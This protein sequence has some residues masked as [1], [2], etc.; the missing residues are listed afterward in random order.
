MKNSYFKKNILI[1][2]S[3]CVGLFSILIGGIFFVIHQQKAAET[4]I[5]AIN[6]KILALQNQA[7][8]LENESAELKKYV[9]WWLTFSENKKSIKTVKI[10]E[11]N[12][13]LINVAEKYSI[14]NPILKTALP[15]NLTNNLFNRKTVLVFFSSCSISFK[16][17]NDTKTLAFLKE[18]FDSLPGYHVINSFSIKKE[19]AYS[20]QDLIDISSRKS[21]GNLNVKIDFFWYNLRNKE[22]ENTKNVAK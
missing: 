4:Q 15:E 21:S 8:E 9:S 19:S 20:Q 1:N 22:I 2:C 7:A 16:A 11:I 10:D 12:S 18:F 14:T 5:S 6:N 13:L 3:L 17:L